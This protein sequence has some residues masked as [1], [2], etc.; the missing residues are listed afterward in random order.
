MA[1]EQ[2]PTQYTFDGLAAALAKGDAGRPPA[3]VASVFQTGLN[4][5]RDLEQKG[6]RVIGID[7]NP[8][9]PGFRSRYAKSFLCPNPDKRPDDWVA[10]ML[11]LS[12]AIGE[13]PVLIAASDIFVSAIGRHVELLNSHFV[14]SAVGAKLQAALATKETQYALAREYGLPSPLA[15]HIQSEADLLAFCRHARF[16]AL[17]KPLHHREWQALPASNPLAGLK[18]ISANSAEDLFAHYESV[19]HLVPNAVAQEEIVGP[20]SA[21]YCY[22]SVYAR[23]GPAPRLLR[24][25]GAA[26]L[27]A[28]L[29]LCHSGRAGRRRR[30]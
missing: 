25:A 14:F 17:L 10:F 6:V 12:T 21:K 8:D 29:W 9:N 18:T 1:A 4:L 22:L 30:D 19:R 11:A 7:L 24:R 23:S 28:A 5:M 2:K 15:A 26:R 27:P 3:V 20:D 16:P 13:R